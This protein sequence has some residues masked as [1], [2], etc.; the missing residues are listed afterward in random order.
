MQRLAIIHTCIMEN[1][2]R[3]AYLYN[4][5]EVDVTTGF[6]KCVGQNLEFPIY[7]GDKYASNYYNNYPRYSWMALSKNFKMLNFTTT[8]IKP[9]KSLISVETIKPTTEVLNYIERG[10]VIGDFEKPYILLGR[11]QG[12]SDY[13]VYNLNTNKMMT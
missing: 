6:L 7:I 12:Y 2:V 4:L 8:F 13:F 10:S 5:F 3:Q 11:G 9:R 1:N